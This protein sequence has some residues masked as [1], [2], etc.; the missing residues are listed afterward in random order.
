[1]KETKVFKR[2][3]LPDDKKITNKIEC[4]LDA[5]KVEKSIIISE[6]RKLEENAKIMYVF[7]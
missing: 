6:I 1:M 3:F 5:C 7:K 2:D 4:A